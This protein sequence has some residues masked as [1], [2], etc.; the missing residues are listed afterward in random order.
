MLPAGV[1]V[2]GEA[3]EV[4]PDKIVMPPAPEEFADKGDATAAGFA[5]GGAPG[6]P[7]R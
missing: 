2:D 3:E 5:A 6:K 4:P 7:A 1:A